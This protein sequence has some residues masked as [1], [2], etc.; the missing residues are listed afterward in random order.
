MSVGGIDFYSTGYSSTF[1]SPN[2][3]TTDATGN[4]SQVRP[5]PPVKTQGT[6]D[7]NTDAANTDNTSSANTNATLN[8]SPTADQVKSASDTGR[9]RGAF[10]DLT[11]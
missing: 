6:S 10:V 5:V 2:A 11:V 3:G 4:G 8:L 9:T 7:G 1:Q